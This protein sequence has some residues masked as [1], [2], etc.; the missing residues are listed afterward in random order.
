MARCDSY[1]PENCTAGACQ[2][3]PWIPDYLGDGGDW[4]ASWAARGGQVTMVPTALS[5]VCYC[6][7]GGYS[8]FGH[9]ALVEVV[10]PD[11][12]FLVREENFLGLGDWDERR[13]TMGDVC[14]FLLA[15][16]MRPGQ[17]PPTGSGQGSGGAS[18]Q[19][20]AQVSQAWENVR[21]WTDAGSSWELGRQATVQQLLAGLPF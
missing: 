8:D 1:T 16:G 2:L 10:Y 9:V 6:R 13:S 19:L 20:P 7:G 14:G 18:L 21:W 5:V 12:T 4:A 3:A 11:G 15:P 17:P